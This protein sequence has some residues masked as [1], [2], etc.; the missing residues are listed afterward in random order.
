MVHISRE[1][2]GNEYQEPLLDDR[3]PSERREGIC[4]KTSKGRLEMTARFRFG[5][6]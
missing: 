2:E 4:L 6:D 1:L 3:K 5:S